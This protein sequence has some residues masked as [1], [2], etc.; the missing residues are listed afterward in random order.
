[1]ILFWQIIASLLGAAMG[2][3]SKK[4]ERDAADARALEEKFA[5]ESANKKQ[6]R[7][8]NLLGSAQQMVSQG[9]A[10]PGQPTT[11]GMPAQ[12]GVSTTS[13]V[14]SSVIPSNQQPAGSNAGA[15]GQNLIDFISSKQEPP[16]DP[17]TNWHPPMS[18]PADS[19]AL[20]DPL[21]TSAGA[22]VGG[23]AFDSA[24]GFFGAAASGNLKSA[25]IQSIFSKL[26]M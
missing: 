19:G 20:A 18:L 24:A 23:G 15:V 16:L 3:A 8:N 17:V 10:Q 6:V 11:P 5:K 21:G 26:F 9:N 1:M 2:N 22:N 13:I 25:I 12:Q 14:P 7:G 4:K